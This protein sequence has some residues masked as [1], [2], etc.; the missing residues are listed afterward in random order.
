MTKPEAFEIA[1]DLRA[2]YTL[3]VLNCSNIL[4]RLASIDTHSEPDAS[5]VAFLC[6]MVRLCIRR[7]QTLELAGCHF[8]NRDKIMNFLIRYKP[9]SGTDPDSSE[10][11]MR[12][13]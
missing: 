1:F 7:P 13:N 11:Q 8:C 3:P 4:E 9:R 5:T 12:L 10:T 6:E 2:I